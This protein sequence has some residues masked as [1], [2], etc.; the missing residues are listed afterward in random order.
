[1]F[2]TSGTSSRDF[3]KLDG[4]RESVPTMAQTGALQYAAVAGWQ[5][6]E[7]PYQNEDVVMDVLLPPAD[8]S[9]QASAGLD[10]AR[11]DAIVGAMAPTPVRLE[12]PKFHVAGGTTS[13]KAELQAL[14]MAAAFDNGDFGGIAPRVTL[15]DVFHEAY[16]DVD[17]H[18][19]EAAAATGGVYG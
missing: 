2:A 18:G 10:A 3:T 19:T 12:L 17:E 13:M 6:V 4:T 8:Q 15:T 14:G 5:A 1:E 11:V 16:V 7:L 9:A